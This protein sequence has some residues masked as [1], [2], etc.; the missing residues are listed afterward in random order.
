MPELPE[1]ESFRKYF[2]TT[3]LHDP[4]AGVEV[5]SP[6]VLGDITPEELRRRLIGMEFTEV[7]RRGKYL[8]AATGDDNSGLILHFGMTGFLAYFLDMDDEPGHERVLITFLSGY[9]LAFDDQRKF[10]RVSFTEDAEE[11]FRMKN[12]G[13]DALELSLEQFLDLTKR[14]RRHIKPLLMDQSFVS[15]VGNIYSDEILYQAGIHPL[16]T[17]DMLDRKE[18]ENLYRTLHRVLETA[19]ECD[20]DIDRY[21]DDWLLKHRSSGAKC[22]RGDCTV[23]KIRVSGRSTYLCPCRQKRVGD[24]M[25][26]RKS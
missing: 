5:S 13:P 6:S 2:E 10:G 18:K 12:V 25:K 19:V 21:P 24:W 14:P 15:G 3:S 16:T 23:E 11:F 26:C 20:A 17:T 8:F 9:H 1:V 22:P 4:I 7:S